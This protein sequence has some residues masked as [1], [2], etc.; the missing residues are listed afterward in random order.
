MFLIQV[1]FCCRRDRK[2]FLQKIHRHH[3]ILNI[4]FLKFRD[5]IYW[6]TPSNFCFQF[7]T[8][9][10]AIFATQYFVETND[11]VIEPIP[12]YFNDNISPCDS[13][14]CSFIRDQSLERNLTDRIYETQTYE[15][16]TCESSNVVYAIHCI[17]CGQMY[18]GETGRS[19]YSSS[20]HYWRWPKSAL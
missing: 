13:I 2:I 8:L 17:R 4:S 12:E 3:D 14:A 11:I 19:H 1:K 20:R 10:N 16:L 7:E 15:Q 9:I 5:T 6:K 18:V